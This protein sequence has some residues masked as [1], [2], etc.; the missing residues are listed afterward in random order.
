MEKLVFSES[1]E[2]HGTCP[3]SCVAQGKLVD[4][5]SLRFSHLLVR[6]TVLPWWAAWGWSK[7][8]SAQ[9][10]LSA[11]AH[12]VRQPEGVIVSSETQRR[13]SSC[14]VPGI[15]GPGSHPQCRGVQRMAGQGYT[16]FC[17]WLRL[18]GIGWCADRRICKHSCVHA[19]AALP[20]LMAR[21]E[22]Q[23]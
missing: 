12:P 18:V 22:G 14:W 11:H 3:N 9:T 16:L 15:C 7:T 2:G 1:N 10:S 19:H 21:R 5:Q 13:D 23:S 4:L 17:G 6:T 20:Q 8:V